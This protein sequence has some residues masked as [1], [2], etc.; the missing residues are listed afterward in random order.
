MLLLPL[1][2][3]LCGHSRSV[4][5]LC[6]YLHRLRIFHRGRIAMTLTCREQDVLAEA[7][8]G[9]NDASKTATSVKRVIIGRVPDRGGRTEDASRVD[10]RCED[11]S[12]LCFSSRW[13]RSWRICR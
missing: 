13:G 5:W 2:L 7:S 12:L 6:V 8:V 3:R 1:L 11:S 10:G 9:D 4:A